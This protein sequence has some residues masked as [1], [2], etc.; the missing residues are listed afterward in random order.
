[1][2]STTERNIILDSKD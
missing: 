1:M 2:I